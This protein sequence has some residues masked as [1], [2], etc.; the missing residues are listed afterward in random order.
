MTTRPLPPLLAVALSLVLALPGCKR[1]SATAGTSGEAGDDVALPRPD[2][3]A[4]SVTGMPDEP[5]PG[6]IGP[7][8]VADTG[9]AGDPEIVFDEEVADPASVD[10]VPGEP[11]AA[12]AVAVLRDYYA[13]IGAR[14]YARAHALWSDG[15]RASG[16]TLEQFANGFANT[17]SVV[18]EP[19][20]P[21][22]VEP[23]AGS[24]Y[25]EVPVSITATRDDGSVHRYLG[26]YTLRRAVV[27][28]ASAEQRAWR[29]ATADIREVTARSGN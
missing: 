28:G 20:E 22:R 15:G 24:R 25:I 2:A 18:A 4:G 9:S 5:G 8:T 1:E 7:P 14:D 11:S 29:I 21:G 6:A 27:D 17:A 12:D 3:G 23:A 26:N 19:G 16:Q 13:A 10:V